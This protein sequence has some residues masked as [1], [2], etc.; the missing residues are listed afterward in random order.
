M[1]GLGNQLFQLAFGQW[2][3]AHNANVYL[4]LR[5]EKSAPGRESRVNQIQAFNSKLPMFA[6][7]MAD[8]VQK[9]AVSPRLQIFHGGRVCLL[10]LCAADDWL[11]IER[12]VHSTKKFAAHVVIGYFQFHRLIADEQCWKT[13]AAATA[14]D[15]QPDVAI[16]DS[17]VDCNK[18]CIIHLRRGDY[19]TLGYPV[20]SSAYYRRALRELRNNGFDGRLFVMTDDPLGLD[21]D[22]GEAATLLDISDPLQ[23]MSV[24]SKFKFK[25]TANSTFSLWGALFGAKDSCVAYPKHWPFFSDEMLA[26][27]SSQGWIG[28]DVT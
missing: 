18:D 24:F 4:L 7:F 6:G 23:S 16:F 10:D 11:T 28:V 25:V 2:L 20:L 13:K 14:L 8:A 17:S 3:E 15:Q 22:L 9:M 19:V 1:G 26:I 5:S 21:C 12:S 27:C